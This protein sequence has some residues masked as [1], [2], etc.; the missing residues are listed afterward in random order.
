[1]PRKGKKRLAKK[2]LSKAPDKDRIGKIQFSSEAGALIRLI[3][4]QLSKE[5]RNATP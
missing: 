4:E 3:A 1:M 5:V 2:K